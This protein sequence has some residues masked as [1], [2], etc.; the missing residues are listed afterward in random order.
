MNS[1]QREIEINVLKNFRLPKVRGLG[2]GG[3]IGLLGFMGIEYRLWVY[4][5]EIFGVR[6]CIWLF[7]GFKT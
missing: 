1:P 2:L 3:Y 6:V 4:G 5:L 7:S